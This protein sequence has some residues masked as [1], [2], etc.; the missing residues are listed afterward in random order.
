[1]KGK[2]PDRAN[3]HRD[4]EYSPVSLSGLP[5]LTPYLNPIN[6]GNGKNNCR[7]MEK[8]VDAGHSR[9]IDKLKSHFIEHFQ[10]QIAGVI[11][12]ALGI[13]MYFIEI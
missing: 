6:K 1:V 10:R 4:G 2:R 9:G 7:Q 12:L 8:I 11:L 3:R 5:S 13:A